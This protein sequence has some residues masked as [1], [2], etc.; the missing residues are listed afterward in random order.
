M[1]IS[2]LFFF[3]F[4]FYFSFHSLDS[5][6]G[7][8]LQTHYTAFQKHL[9]ST[10]LPNRNVLPKTTAR[11]QIDKIGPLS[12]LTPV[13]SRAN[14]M[15]FSSSYFWFTYV[16]TDSKSSPSCFQGWLGFPSLLEHSTE[17]R[18]CPWDCRRQLCLGMDVKISLSRCT[19]ELLIHG[20]TLNDAWQ[21]CPV[22]GSH[23]AFAVW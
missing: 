7:C 9:S 8:Q 2:S 15:H 18:K 1:F 12:D 13:V 22:M 17:N 21:M 14:T 4:L 20:H 23:V 3:H 6:P 16:L 19:R 5:K 10:S 11:E